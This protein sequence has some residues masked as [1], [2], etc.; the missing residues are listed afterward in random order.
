MKVSVIISS[1]DPVGLTVKRLGYSFEEIEDEVT[2]FHYTKGDAIVMICRHESS[3]RTPA[4][5]VHH[6]GNPGQNPLGGEPETLGI[7]NPR[8][9]TSIYR[10][11]IRIDTEVPKVIEATHHGPSSL[12]VPITF[13]EIG[14]DPSMWTNEKM[15]KSL[16]DAVLEGI[17]RAEDIDCSNTMLIYGGPHYSKVAT[18]RA[19]DGCISHIISKHYITGIKSHVILQSIE[20]NII[21]PKTAILDSIARL[22]RELLTDILSSN[23]ISIELR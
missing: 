9:L 19:L 23:N 20:R 12:P 10:S 21:R 16:V 3:S 15:V 7:A 14:S 4:L 11:L 6:P 17:E 13:V 5:T 2:D 1:K 22:Q 18:S 8:L